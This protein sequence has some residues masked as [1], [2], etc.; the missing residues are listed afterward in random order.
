MKYIFIL[1]LSFPFG[2]FGQLK[3]K[4]VRIADGDTFTILVQEKQYR[5]RLHGI[6]SPEKGQ[7]FSVA[8]KQ[9]LSDL[10]MHRM[11]EVKQKNKDRYGR[12]IGIATIDGVNINESLLR[13]G[14]AWHFTRYDRNPEWA[15]LEQTARAERKGLWAQGNP[16]APWEFRK[17]R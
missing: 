5:I 2:V 15:L 11:V 16:L 8:A 1:L 14:Y 10:I 7:D 12:I 6:D 9:Y 4:V 13:Q 17:S 3:G